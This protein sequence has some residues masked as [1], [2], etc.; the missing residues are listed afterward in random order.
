MIHPVTS[1]RRAAWVAAACAVLSVASASAYPRNPADIAQADSTVAPVD[2]SQVAPAEAPA[3]TPADTARAAPAETLATAPAKRVK[4][5][6]PAKPK[7]PQ[8]SYE[9]RR[10]EDGVHARGANWLGLRAGYAKRSGESSGQ[11]LVGYGIQY[12]RM[13][14]NKY[15]FAVGTG[16][17]VVG[18][19]QSQTDHAVPFTAEFQRHFRWKG[20]TQ[21]YV[22]LGGGYYYRKFYRTDS[23]YNTHTTGGAHVSVGFNSALGDRHVIGIE[24][25]G[26]RLQGR[27][28]ITNPTFG[29]SDDSE[30]I[31]TLKATWALVY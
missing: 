21:P 13:L 12:Q 17:D 30:A 24:G 14:S 26:A 6:K 31:W 1:L 19:F 15:A 11:G 25:R 27:A 8:K 23:E 22:G 5:K 18:H 28:G 7:P 29:I 10:R 3:V 2:T 16:H 20:A 9:E 4:E